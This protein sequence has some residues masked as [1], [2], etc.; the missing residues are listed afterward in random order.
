MR[1]EQY[2]TFTDHAL[3]EVIV[4]GD[5]VSSVASAST[6]G[7]IPPKTAKQKIARKNELKAKSTLMLAIPDE[8]L[9]KFHACFRSS[10]VNLKFMLDNEDF[11]Q[12][13]TDDLEEMDLKWRG[14]FASECRAPKKQ[15]NRNRDAPT[16]NAPVDTSTTNALV[17]QD[18]IGGYDWSFQAE[19]E[20][21][22]FA[23]MAHISSSLSSDSEV[24]TFSKECLKSYN[25]LQKDDGDDNQ[26][27]DRFKKGEGYH[28]VLLPYIRNYMPPRVDLSFAGLDNSVFKSKVSETIISV[29]KIETNASKTSNDS[30]EK[31]KTIR[32]SAPIIEDL[33]SDIEDENVFETKESLRGNKRNWKNLMTQRLGDN[34][35]FKNK[36]CYECGS[37]N[38]LIKDCDSYKKKMVEKLV[39]NNARR[40]NHQ[41]SQRLSHPRLKRN[42]VPKAVLTNSSL[43]TLN[44]ARQTSSRVA[45]S[46]NTARPINT[47]Y[48]RSTMNGARPAL[49][50]FNKVHSHDRRPFNKFTTNKNSTLN[51]KVNTI[52]GNGTTAGS[53]AVVS[54]KGNEANAVKALTCWIWRPKQKVLDHVS[55]HNGALMNFKR[56]DYVDAQGKSKSDEE[57]DC[58]YVSF[59]GEPKGGKVTDTKCVV[60]SPNFKLLDESQVLLRVPRKKN[61]YS[62]DLRNVVLSRG[63]TCLFAKA[64]LDVYNLWH[65]RLWVLVVKPHNTTSYELFLGRKPALSFMR[66]FGCPVTI[67]NTL[68]HLGN[69]TNGNAGTKANID[70]GQAK[71]KIVSGLQYVLLPL[72]TSNSQGLK[73][74]ED[75]VAD[76]AGKKSTKVPRKENEVQ[77]PAKEGDKNNQEKDVRDQEEATRKQFEQESKRLLGR[78]RTQR[79]EFEN[80]P[81]DPL[82]PDLE[83]TADIGIFSG[84]YDDEV[85]GAVADFNNLELTAIVSPFS[86][87]RIHKDHPKEQIIGD[88]ILAPQTRRMT[89]I[90]QENAMMDVKSAFLYDTIEE[91][92]YVCQP[93]GFE[94]PHFPNKVYKSLKDNAQE[95]PDEFYGGAHFLLRVAIKTASIP[96][97]ITKALLKDEEVVDVDVHLYKLMIGSLMYLT[98]SRLYIMF[99]I[100]AC[101]RFHVKPKVSYLYAVKRIFRY[102]KGQPKLGLWYPRDSSFDLEA[103][104]YSDY[105]G[106]SLDK[107]STIKGC[108]FLE[109]PVEIEGFEHIV[110][111]LNA[112]PTKYALTVNLTIYTS[113]IQQF[114]DSAKV[115]TVNEDVQIRDLIDGKKIIVTEASIRR[116]L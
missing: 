52:K 90:Y 105:A 32:S 9:L 21:T 33:E 24:H 102:L 101:A 89:K 1:M 100:C 113:C 40:V 2:L 70:A 107:R 96:I 76:D 14:H 71:K 27:N 36:A 49:N 62:V 81:T 84:A 97:E 23:L 80:L 93:L 44:T 4:N 59:G 63:L 83:D 25:A 67:L 109:K 20:L 82:M 78:E 46:V 6:E 72:L 55:R 106:A 77:D 31:P 18:G 34:F 51:Q 65:R 99:A 30:L 11:E 103:F 16:R 3:W 50:I 54:N 41:N 115:K 29:S 75:E 111:F 64:T 110:D 58:G 19:E 56:F 68:D 45:V 26:V 47:T 42:F 60:L 112:N 87:T 79:N 13:D 114:W 66:P 17:V 116:D 48:P 38:H 8:H 88:R 86:T 43:K 5:S 61:M 15:G 7:P 94:D 108:Q 35:E 95:V 28:A 73:S 53:K 74:L 57:I 104:S 10:S 39:W 37:F 12:I 69:Q 98:A 85:E 92:V 91:E 22:N